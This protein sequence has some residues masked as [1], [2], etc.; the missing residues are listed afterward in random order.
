MDHMFTFDGLAPA[1]SD[2]VRQELV[3]TNRSDSE[4]EVVVMATGDTN[5]R[6]RNLFVTLPPN[7]TYRVCLDPLWDYDDLHMISWLPFDA[8]LEVDTGAAHRE[9]LPIVVNQPGSH[10]G[11]PDKYA[12][13]CQERSVY[14]RLEGN[15]LFG[16]FERA[17]MGKHEGELLLHMFWPNH[18]ELLHT[19][20]VAVSATNRLDLPRVRVSEQMLKGYEQQENRPFEEPEMTIMLVSDLTTGDFLPSRNQEDMDNALLTV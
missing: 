10:L 6:I 3:L 18:G 5:G 7:E 1:P 2:E 9:T 12:A 17:I 19:V 4:N 13:W 16:Y 8:V 15:Y 20:N 14:R 11:Q